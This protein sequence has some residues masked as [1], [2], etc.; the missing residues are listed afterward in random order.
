MPLILSKTLMIFCKC[1][2]L[3]LNEGYYEG[4]LTASASVIMLIKY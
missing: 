3:P 2:I 4:N 1:I